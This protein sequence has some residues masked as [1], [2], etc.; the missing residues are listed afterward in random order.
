YMNED[1]A[2]TREYLRKGLELDPNSAELQTNYGVAL[3]GAQQPA[4]ALDHFRR[5]MA[6]SHETADTWNNI[7]AAYYAL[8]DLDQAI[9]SYQRGLKFDPCH[10]NTRRNLVM[11]YAETQRPEAA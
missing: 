4:E 1:P 9:S 6:L 11:L 10:D 5:A 7:G 8:H 2:R 3:M